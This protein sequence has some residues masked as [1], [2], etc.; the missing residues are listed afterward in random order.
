LFLNDLTLVLNKEMMFL[1]SIFSLHSELWC[2]FISIKREIFCFSGELVQATWNGSLSFFLLIETKE[3]LS[4]RNCLW[5]LETYYKHNTDTLEH[6]YL[7]W[8]AWKLTRSSTQSVQRSEWFRFGYYQFFSGK[9]MD[10]CAFYVLY[11]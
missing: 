1:I 3:M 7:V 10:K 8:Q 5:L 11:S 2:I 9:N 6:F 4:Y